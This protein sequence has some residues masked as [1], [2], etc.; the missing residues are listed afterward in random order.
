MWLHAMIKSA[1]PTIKH[2]RTHTTCNLQLARTSN[3]MCYWTYNHSIPATA[4]PAPPRASDS[5][6]ACGASTLAFYWLYGRVLESFKYSYTSQL[7]HNP[8]SASLW[9][10]FTRYLVLVHRSWTRE[11]GQYTDWFQM[12]V[13]L[14]LL[15]LA[16]WA[17]CPYVVMLT[18]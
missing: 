13:E 4:Y 6:V 5:L 10:S 14:W 16:W 12:W 2:T 3:H 17:A 9:Q 15:S 8:D 1:I 11:H 18:C 7:I